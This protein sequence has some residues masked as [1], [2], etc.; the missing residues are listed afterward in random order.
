MSDYKV[1]KYLNFALSGLVSFS[2][3]AKAENHQKPNVLFFAVDDL[4]PILGC[5]GDKIIKTPNID[6]L[7]KRSSVFRSNYCQQ[8][9]SGPTRASIMTGMRPDYTKVY[10]L[11]TKMRDVNPDI[12]SIPQYFISQGYSSQGIGKVY[13][14]RCVDE[15]YDK[16]SWSV[17]YNNDEEID[18]KYLDP[19]FGLPALRGYQLPQTK[20]LINKY[21]DEAIAKGLTGD[22]INDY[23]SKLIAPSVECADV[24]DN[25]YNDGVVALKSKKILED[26]KKENKPFFFAVGFHKPHLPF[27]SPK[28]YWDLYKREEMPLAEYQ[29]VAVNSPLMAYNNFYE[30]RYYSDIP[31]LG[32]FTDQTNGIGI[33][34]DEKQRELI[35]G[36]YAAISYMDAQVGIV[37]NALDSLGLADNTIIVL[38]GDHGWHLGDHGLWCKHTNF[39]QATHAPLIISAPK[40][41]ASA[42]SSQTEFVDVFPT[43]CDLAGLKIPTHLDGQSLV[44][45]MKNPIAKVKEFSVSQYPKYSLDFKGEKSKVTGA[46]DCMGYSIRNSR[47]RFTIWMNDNFRTSQVFDEK[48]LIASE[49]YDYKVDP[50]E[51]FNVVDDKKYAITRK[52]MYSQ[53]LN[54]FET[55]RIKLNKGSK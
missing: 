9:L 17:P 26:L 22:K 41:K 52:E 38:W 28:K 49:L 2:C 13:D 11:Q 3:F 37:L 32:S 40:Y 36:Y 1:S 45:L 4:K 15:F 31:P 51:T 21:K 24:T 35:H 30:L 29:K 33:L 47:Y 12:L 53:M 19:A 7:A 27:I 39:E 10:T 8:A 50:N 25:A 6:K 54:Y 34:P 44:P 14:P 43:L 48:R 42:T 16:A 46:G 55:Q 23:V 18:E 20:E 5:Y